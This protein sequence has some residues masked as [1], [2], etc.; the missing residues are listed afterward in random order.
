MKTEVLGYVT[1]KT[2]ELLNAASC[3]AEARAAAE[4]WLAA[5]GSEAEAAATAEYLTVL[6]S[7]IMP[8]GM[9]IAFADSEAGVQ[10]F[11]AEMAKNIAAHAR[12]IQ[13]AGAVYCDCPACTAV[14]AILARKSEML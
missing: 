13:A 10:V 4:K 14:A 11:G 5:V 7:C 3:S 6:E 12:E 2:R 8:V 9:L 1:E